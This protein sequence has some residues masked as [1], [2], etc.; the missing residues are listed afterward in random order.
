MV[1][2]SYKASQS[3]DKLT[4]LF[5]VASFNQML[6][7]LQ[8][9][10]QY[11]D[12]RRFQAAQILKVEE[13]LQNEVTTYEVARGQKEDLIQ[14][15]I[16]EKNKLSVL[17]AKQ[18]NIDANLKIREGE[19]KFELENRR[20]AVA[21][22][23]NLITRIIAEEAASATA[24]A[25]TA[26]LAELSTSFEGNNQRLPWPVSRGFISSGFGKHN[27]PVFNKVLIDNKGVYIQ[28]S[29]SEE[30]KA[31]F[32]GRVSIVASIPGMNKAVI[33][34]HGDYRTVYAN[35]DEVFVSKNQEI[36]VNDAIGT[37]YTDN[38]GLSELYFEVWKK[39][40]TLNP[41]QWLSKR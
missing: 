17:I 34:Q 21:E 15:E 19:L 16:D 36:Q 5:S 23:S 27:H 18:Q 9:F 30:I 40:V 38:D 31:V 3:R 26:A 13:S 11:Q 41:Q 20:K 7:R 37:V 8:Y 12:A 24:F 28:T 14:D 25:S 35:L 33:V 39:N 1:Y 10:E 6:L 22:I 4:F 2:A 29:S 32:G